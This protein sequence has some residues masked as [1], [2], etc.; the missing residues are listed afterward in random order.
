M[1]YIQVEVEVDII[2][3]VVQ[4][5]QLKVQEDQEVEDQEVQ[6]ITLQGLLEQQILV[7]AEVELQT[8]VHIINLVVMEVQGWC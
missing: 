1:D 3:V 2:L 5:H 6:V 4:V 8:K 7:V